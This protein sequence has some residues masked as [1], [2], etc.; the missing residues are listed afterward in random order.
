MAAAPRT[1][2][3]IVEPTRGINGDITR[4]FSAG[5]IEVGDTVAVLLLKSQ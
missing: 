3:N 5:G 2:I 4:T 1:R